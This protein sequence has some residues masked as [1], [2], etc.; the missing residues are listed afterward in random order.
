MSSLP[1][2]EFLHPIFDNADFI[3]GFKVIS[4][5]INIFFVSFEKCIRIVI[6]EMFMNSGNEM[7]SGNV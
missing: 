2:N 4:Y 5:V 7:N 6:N 3:E 1:S